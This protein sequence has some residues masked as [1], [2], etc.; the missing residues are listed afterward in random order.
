MAKKS[1]AVR[2]RPK[3]FS[4]VCEQGE[5][6][7]IF[8]YCLHNNC[9]PNSALLCGSAGTG[10]TSLARIIAN[11]L[12]KGNGTPIELDA[13]SNNGV[14]D[15]RNIIE[16]SKYRSLD[17]EYKIFIIDECHSLSNNAWQAFL[18]LLEEPNSKTIFL[19]CTTD[20]Q[21][22]PATILSRVQRFD[23]TRITYGTIVKR[24]KHI[25]EEE[26]KLGERI[27]YEINAV[28]YIAKL[29]SGGMRDA[30]TMMDKCLGYDGNLTVPNVIASLGIQDYSV[31][32]DFT[33]FLL[34]GEEEHALKLINDIYLKGQ[35]IKQFISN[36]VQFLMDLCKYRIL[37]S[38]EY[39][40]IPDTYGKSLNYSDN[41]YK[42]IRY[43]LK[44]IIN[45]KSFVKWEQSPKLYLEAEILKLCANGE[46]EDKAP[47]EEN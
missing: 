40:Q 27:T 31:M 19:F 22:I 3:T 10:K 42:Y 15:V 20:P 8:E 12:N 5:V 23:F 34:D 32:F 14:D 4:D 6:I 46:K 7:K 30:I 45:L 24:L 16:Q 25:L 44:S 37:K 41:D 33:N 18:K 9:F 21:K 11:E 2:Y 35:D 17:A 43:F 39:I 29:A 26:I 13:A 1:L 28:E 38:Y 47:W 36:Y